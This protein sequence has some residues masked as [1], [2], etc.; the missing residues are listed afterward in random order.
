[1]LGIPL[2]EISSNPG[3]FFFGRYTLAATTSKRS[4]VKQ[5]FQKLQNATVAGLVSREG[6][7]KFLTW[8]FVDQNAC[9]IFLL[10]VGVG[11][12]CYTSKTPRI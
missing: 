3:F 11:G 12:V 8:D 7:G 1:M 2:D 10:V 4:H 6:R 9:G 5:N